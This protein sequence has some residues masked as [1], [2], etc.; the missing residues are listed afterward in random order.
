MFRRKQK[1]CIANSYVI[2]EPES[3]INNDGEMVTEMVAQNK[4]LP[5]ADMFDLGDMID[6]GI[7]QEEVKSSILS[8]S[9]V[10]ADSVV[11][12]YTKKA[13]NESSNNK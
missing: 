11:R 13:E 1:L 7:D 4:S 5:S 3:H 9:S 10:N 2:Y 8:P 12:K 6:A